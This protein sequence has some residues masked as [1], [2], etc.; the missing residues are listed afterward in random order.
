MEAYAIAITM[1]QTVW[2]SDNKWLRYSKNGSKITSMLENASQTIACDFPASQVHL[3]IPLWMYSIAACGFAFT[4]KWH[5]ICGD[6][7]SNML[8]FLLSMLE[9]LSHLFSD[10]QMGCSIVI[11]IS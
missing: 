8:E 10:F 4:S 7:F 6:A 2:K 11:V 9:Y 1:L 5:V 3:N